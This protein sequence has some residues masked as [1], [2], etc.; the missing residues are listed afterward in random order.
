VRGDERG[1]V[2]VADEA[3]PDAVPVQH[4]A[5][6]SALGRATVVPAGPSRPSGI[7]AA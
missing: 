1:Q 4:R 3:E 2:L 6:I 5:S 7:L